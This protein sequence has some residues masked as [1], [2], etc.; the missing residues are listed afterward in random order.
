MSERH[1]LVNQISTLDTL[2]WAARKMLSEPYCDD[3]L[4][5]YHLRVL[6]AVRAT[7]AFMHEHEATIRAAI[8][9]ERLTK[10][11]GQG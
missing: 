5:D 4:T 9:A 6:D 7:L 2:T 10:D 3:R 11:A 8:A 1:S